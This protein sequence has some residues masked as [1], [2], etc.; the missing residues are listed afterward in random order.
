[1]T[2]YFEVI[3]A[4]A[5]HIYHS[6]LVLTP[7][8]SM[9]RK[10]YESHARP[11]ARAVHGLPISWD[12]TTAAT[13]RPSGI[14]MVAW[15]PCARFI[16]ISWDDTMKVEVLDSVTLQR[17]QTLETL[18]AQPISTEHSALAFSPDSRILTCISANS[19]DKELFVVSWDLQTGDIASVI[20]WQG[21]DFVVR[22]LSITYL[23]DG[24]TV[25]IRCRY[26]TGGESILVFDVASGVYVRSHSTAKSTM[27]PR[28]IWI[29][30]ESLRFTTINTEAITIWEVGFTSEAI[31][32][33]VETFPFPPLPI[34][35]LGDSDSDSDS[36][37]KSEEYIQFLPAPCRL[38]RN[39]YGDVSVWDLQNSE[40]LLHCTDTYFD[41]WMSFSSDGRFFACSA[42]TSGIYLWKESATGDY[43]LHEILE[44]QIIT[45]YPLLSRNGESIVAFGGTAIR[46]WRTKGHTPP[47]PPSSIITQASQDTEIPQHEAFLLDFSPDGMLAAFARKTDRTVTVLNPKSGVLRLTI[48]AGMEVHGLGV[49]GNTITVVSGGEFTTWDLPTGDRV[50]GAKMTQGDHVRS[51]YFTHS[52][53]DRIVGVSISPDSRHLVTTSHDE[54]LRLYDGSTGKELGWYRTGG[55][56]PFF[57]P[58]GRDLWL[59]GDNGCGEVI[60]VGDGGRVQQD[61]ERRVDIEDPPEGYPWASSRGCRVADN[62]WILGPDGK[63][64][65]MLPPP[66][67]SFMARQ[68]VWKGQYLALLHCELLEPVILEL[69]Q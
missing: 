38:A 10:L 18:Q 20:R 57:A 52:M 55:G 34:D 45:S 66:W 14:T 1:M 33:E 58:V 62:R 42:Y 26:S 37:D 65:L 46:S 35:T 15:S 44:F 67:R 25:G 29:H 13:I 22:T 59:V 48:D 53:S 31:P 47:P 32:T 40:D 16:A 49:I 54:I 39:S 11:F 60:R 43:I 68:R 19:P 27:C 5:P 17:L 8:Q 6:A 63:R 21:P 69:Y 61:P 3:N 2:G 51:T 50:P 56:I 4:S 28:D 41:Q 64:L 7:Q 24:K 9:V 12:G 30:G 23:A 36:D